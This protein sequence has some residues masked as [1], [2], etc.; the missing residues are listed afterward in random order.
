MR[1]P[2]AVAR[3]TGASKSFGIQQG[4]FILSLSKKATWIEGQELDSR[5]DL[6]RKKFND[7][8][9]SIDCTAR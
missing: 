2:S 7:S 3:L 6:F 1:Y 5:H 9:N 4:V 8:V